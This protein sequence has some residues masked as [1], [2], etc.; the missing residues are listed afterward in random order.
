MIGVHYI[1]GLGFRSQPPPD[2]QVYG[3]VPYRNESWSFADFAQQARY[4]LPDITMVA[5]ANAE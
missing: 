4:V 2:L 5:S 3:F 1:W